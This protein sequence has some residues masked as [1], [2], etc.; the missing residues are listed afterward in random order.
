MGILLSSI[1]C[2]AVTRHIRTYLQCADIRSLHY[3]GGTAP[4][5][6]WMAGM[7][8]SVAAAGSAQPLITLAWAKFQSPCLH[9]LSYHSG[10]GRFC[11]LSCESDHITSQCALTHL[12]PYSPPPSLHRLP[13]QSSDQESCETRDI[14]THLFSEKK[15]WCVFLESCQFQH[16]CA[17]CKSK[18]HRAQDCEETPP[19]LPYQFSHPSEWGQWLQWNTSL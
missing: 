17:T 2:S 19:E 11:N 13:P 15:G 6:P 1:Y 9:F 8:Q 7:W 14:R 3:L 4:L 12:Q 16:A 5:W 10:P 18:G